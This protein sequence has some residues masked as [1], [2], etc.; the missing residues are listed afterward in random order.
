MSSNLGSQNWLNFDPAIPSAQGSSQDGG[1]GYGASQAISYRDSL[2][3]ARSGAFGG[4]RIGDATYPDGYLS[5]NGNIGSRRAGRLGQPVAGTINDRSYQRGV[6]KGTKMDPGQYYWPAD[7]NLGTRIA[8]EARARIDPETGCYL[9]RKPSPVGIPVETMIYPGLSK[10]PDGR[11]APT[12]NVAS[13]MV[14]PSEA[15]YLARDLPG[16][17]SVRGVR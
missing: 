2:D 15:A 3:A 17:L 9:V 5:D 16:G 11:P 13:E 10:L 4:G 7:F 12:A 1:G 6:H 8:A 14:D